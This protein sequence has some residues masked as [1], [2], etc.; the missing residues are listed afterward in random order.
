MST[1]RTNTNTGSL[2]GTGDADSSSSSSLGPNRREETWRR[3][4]ERAKEILDD[5]GVILASWRVGGDV[6]DV[7]VWL[8]K[9]ALDCK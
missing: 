2:N 8:V 6:Q 1:R 3:R 7:C 9:E 5:Q 4:W